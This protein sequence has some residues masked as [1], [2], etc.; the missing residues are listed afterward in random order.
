M[1]QPCVGTFLLF[2]KLWIFNFPFLLF[3]SGLTQLQESCPVTCNTCSDGATSTTQATT[4]PTAGQVTCHGVSKNYGMHACWDLPYIYGFD[5]A[6]TVSPHQ[7]FQ[8]MCVVILACLCTIRASA[9]LTKLNP[10]HRP[11]LPLTYNAFPT[12]DV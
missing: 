8:R 3:H 10:A 4:T 7:I 11:P 5:L 2:R 9:S 1:S 6:N 12:Y